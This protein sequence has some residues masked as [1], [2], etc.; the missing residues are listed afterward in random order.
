V[1]RVQGALP[2]NDTTIVIYDIDGNNLA[3]AGNGIGAAIPGNVLTYDLSFAPTTLTFDAFFQTMSNGSMV[4][5]AALAVDVTNFTAQKGNN[6]NDIKLT[7][8]NNE[9]V[10]RVVL[11]KSADGVNFSDAGE[12]LKLNNNGSEI[13]YQFT[14]ITPFAVNTFY[15]AK[16]FSA[17]KEQ[18][19]AI[20]RI[21]ESSNTDI[22]V[23]PSPAKD[24]V[25]I[26]FANS[27]REKVT[28][29]IVSAEGKVVA[30]A[31]TNNEFI[32]YNVSNLVSGMYLVQVIKQGQVNTAIKFMVSH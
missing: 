5:L 21:K 27:N 20:V 13:N 8:S 26:S 18:Y 12:M 22:S 29:H 25:N 14:D 6:G 11:Q 28:I 2:A 7:V 3:K 19:T 30:E 23:S 15:R 1:V 17:V 24:M 16:I 10:S 4:P 31:F 32:H 9:P